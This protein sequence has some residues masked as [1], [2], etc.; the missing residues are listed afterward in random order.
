MKD[1]SKVTGPDE[2][3]CPM[4]EI[5]IERADLECDEKFWPSSGQK[6]LSENHVKQDNLISSSSHNN[7]RTAYEVQLNSGVTDSMH[8]SPSAVQCA[9][10]EQLI[11]DRYYLVAVDQN[12]HCRCLRCC[13]CG[14]N[15]GPERSCFARDGRIYCKQDYYRLFCAHK[16]QRCG[17]LLGPDE[18]V[19]KARNGVYYHPDCFTCNVCDSPLHKNDFFG[20][21]DGKI[22]CQFHYRMMIASQ[23]LITS[24]HCL[25]SM[26]HPSGYI[27]SPG[28]GGG[29]P[30]PACP[31]SVSNVPARKASSNRSRKRLRE[32]QIGTNSMQAKGTSGLCRMMM[33]GTQNRNQS[34][35]HHF[36]DNHVRESGK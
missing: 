2:G 28:S 17:L 7:V 14:L 35:N 1:M 32:K 9:G 8:F 34:Q 10:C 18:M 29:A 13:T 16:C 15:L 23:D 27:T 25:S 4:P 3:D 30:D 6:S 26:Q 21:I 33:I 11:G 5:K 31:S 19:M 24:H 36:M 22:L 12:W 20:L